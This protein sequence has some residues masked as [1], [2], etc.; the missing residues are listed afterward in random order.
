MAHEDKPK[1]WHDG[2]AH[3]R[4]TTTTIM[5][6]ALNGGYV[7]EHEDEGTLNAASQIWALKQEL[8]QAKEQ[9]SAAYDKHRA[10]AE[11]I[12]RLTGLDPT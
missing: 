8:E 12:R 6:H 7:T 5:Q 4:D 3:G 11:T 9:L 10:Q 2:H 1:D